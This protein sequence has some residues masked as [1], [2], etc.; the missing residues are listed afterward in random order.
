M[1]YIYK[2][3][4]DLLGLEEGTLQVTFALLGLLVAFITI[5]LS[6]IIAGLMY[7]KKRFLDHITYSGN[8]LSPCNI[9][10]NILEI[11]TIL[12]LPVGDILPSNL[13]FKI[14]LW[15]AIQKCTEQS[16]FIKMNKKAMNVF[17]PCIINGLSSVFSEGTAMK[18]SGKKEMTE[19]F[20]LWLFVTCEQYGRARS[21]KIR[22]MVLNEE[23]M[24]YI[25]SEDFDPVKVEFEEDHHQD[26]VTTLIR[27]SKIW[28][29]ETKI[30]NQV[31]SKR[32]EAIIRK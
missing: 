13:I 17:M 30:G 8:I 2:Y 4:T 3:L 31:I 24:K 12:T 28:R 19:E 10:G 18:I 11:R 14:K 32:F 9:S 29:N 7:L 23:T 16:M 5:I 26:R 22:V 25:L 27:C 20:N 15:W 6:P 21:Q 1:D